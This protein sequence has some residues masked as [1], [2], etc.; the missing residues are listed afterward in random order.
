MDSNFRE[1]SA[2]ERGD[3]PSRKTRFATDCTLAAV[4]TRN[5]QLAV[6]LHLLV[7]KL[8]WVPQHERLLLDHSHSSPEVVQLAKASA[9]S[10]RGVK[11][12]VETIDLP[13][14]KTKSIEVGRPNSLGVGKLAP[15]SEFRPVCSAV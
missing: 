6:V 15:G 4:A 8:P 1:H 9:P 10:V 11:A 7:V 12:D 13:I 5:V 2:V 3:D 14:R